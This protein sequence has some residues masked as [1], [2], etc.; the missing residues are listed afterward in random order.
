MP[1]DATAGGCAA[2][3]LDNICPADYPRPMIP[4]NLPEVGVSRTGVAE[5]R[6][7]F[8]ARNPPTAPAAAMGRLSATMA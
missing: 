5:G 8:E 7:G 1:R 4:A 2:A 6:F 3:R